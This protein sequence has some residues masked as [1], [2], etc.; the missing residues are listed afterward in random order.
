MKKLVISIA[1]TLMAAAVLV[2]CN[3]TTGSDITSGGAAPVTKA[4]CTSLNNW[5]SVGIGMSAD[6][7]QARLGKPSKITSTGTQTQ[8]DYEACRGFVRIDTDPVAAVG[9]TPA[10]PGKYSVI[11]IPGSIVLTSGRGVTSITSPE[12]IKEKIECELDYYNYS[13]DAGKCRTA[14]TPF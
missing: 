1:T 7:V 6:E 10:V 9:A 8:Y 14:S 2:A 3:G 12:R 11:D 5:Q 13:Y 4:V